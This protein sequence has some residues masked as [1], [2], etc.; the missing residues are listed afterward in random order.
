MD[1]L[2]ETQTFSDT[3]YQCRGGDASY[4]GVTPSEHAT[5]WD[6]PVVDVYQKYAVQ[7]SLIAGPV[8]EFEYRDRKVGVEAAQ[9]NRAKHWWDYKTALVVFEFGLRKSEV[10]V[11]GNWCLA[12]QVGLP[13]KKSRI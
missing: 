10:S 9:H 1:G 7:G 6:M 2:A 4:S 12:T 5:P 11:F 3:Q 8:S 13:P